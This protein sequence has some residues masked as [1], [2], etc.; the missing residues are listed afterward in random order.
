VLVLRHLSLDQ[1]YSVLVVG[2]VGS[3]LLT[4]EDLRV[5]VEMAVEVLVVKI[6]LVLMEAQTL[7]VVVADLVVTVQ[8]GAVLVAQ[9][10]LLYAIV[11]RSVA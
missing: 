6:H 11:V 5:L 8:L 9:G 10:S 3:I 7:E 4:L 1:A 2:A